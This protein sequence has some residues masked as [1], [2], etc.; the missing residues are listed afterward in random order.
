MDWLGAVMAVGG[1]ALNFLGEKNAADA[2]QDAYNNNA[3][4]SAKEAE[5]Q[6]FRTGVLEKRLTESYLLAVGRQ[7]A[8]YAK[9]GVIVDEG[10]A[11][12]MVE[13]STRRYNEDKALLLQEGQFNVDRAKMGA[14]NFQS[15]A[16]SAE[17]AGYLRQG[18]TLMQGAETLKNVNWGSGSTAASTSLYSGSEMNSMSWL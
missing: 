5:Y 7:R 4:L 3:A 17:T 10:T 13:E 2:K 18:A 12:A 14:Q 6:Q 8:L 1:T 15:L 11:G 9:S 16:S